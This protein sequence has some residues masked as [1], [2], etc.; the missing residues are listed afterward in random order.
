ME[1]WG[2]GGGWNKVRVKELWRGE[3]EGWRETEKRG[4]KSIRKSGDTV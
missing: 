1:Q 3:K 4:E 2:E